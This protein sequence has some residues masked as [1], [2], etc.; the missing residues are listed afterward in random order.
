[1]TQVNQ[2]PRSKFR[3]LGRKKERK[4]ETLVPDFIMENGHAMRK[5]GHQEHIVVR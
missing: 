5:D 3:K 1:M 4:K 2:E